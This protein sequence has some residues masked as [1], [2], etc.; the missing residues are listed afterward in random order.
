MV[1]FSNPR[2]NERFSAEADALARNL[3]DLLFSHPRIETMEADGMTLLMAALVSAAASLVTALD[4]R[5]EFGEGMIAAFK[6]ID[7]MRRGRLPPLKTAQASDLGITFQ[8]MR[9]AGK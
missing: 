1:D 7:E 4:A 2:E 8:K 5:K 3:I 6:D 9:D